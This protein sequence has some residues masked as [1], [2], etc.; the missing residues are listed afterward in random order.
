VALKHALLAAAA[1]VDARAALPRIARA[2]VPDAR[3]A[4]HRDAEFGL[5]ALADG[6]AGLYYAWLGASQAGMSTRYASSTLVGQDSLALAQRLLHDDDAERSLALAALGAI[7][8]CLHARAGYRPPV[9]EDSMAGVG[10]VPGSRLGM[11]GNFPPLVRR[12]RAVGVHVTV[13]ERKA[14]MVCSEP[15]LDIT[16]DPR[17]LT[18]CE[19]VIVTGA[20]LIND[21]LEDMLGHCRDARRVT[22]IGPTAGVFPDVLFAQGIAAVGGLRIVDAAAACARLEAGERLGD[23]AERWLIEATDYPGLEAL[24]ARA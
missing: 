1:R 16:L 17:A 3:P 23:S 2:F 19:E 5:I 13:V 21:S 15:G 6:S 14:H 4:A 8:A 18:G 22:L 9:A 11:V 12:A 24:L 20:T 10:L 7:T